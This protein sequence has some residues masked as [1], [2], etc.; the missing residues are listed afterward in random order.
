VINHPQT[1]TEEISRVLA[2]ENPEKLRDRLHNERSISSIGDF[3]RSLEAMT[4]CGNSP[5]AIQVAISFLSHEENPVIQ[6][7][8]LNVLEKHSVSSEDELI[9]QTLRNVLAGEYSNTI[10]EIAKEIL[11][12]IS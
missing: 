10:R 3:A 12:D 2:I 6:E 4:I 9:K 8:A 7:A 11:T 5:L 1:L